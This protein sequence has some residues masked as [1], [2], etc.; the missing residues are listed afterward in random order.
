M[1]DSSRSNNFKLEEWALLYDSKFI[2]FKGKLKTRWLGP[3][4]IDHIFNN[5]FVIIITIN[6]E[7]TLILINGHT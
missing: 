6:E 2:Y 1:T 4:E 7:K 3:Y 5:G